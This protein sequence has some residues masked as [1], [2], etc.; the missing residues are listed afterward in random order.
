M[1]TGSINRSNTIEVSKA[2]QSELENAWLPLIES[3]V[4]TP[5]TD[6]RKSLLAR[7]AHVQ[8]TEV[9]EALNETASFGTLGYATGT[10]TIGLGN[11]SFGTTIGSGQAGF[12][13]GS[14]GSG[15]KWMSPFAIAMQVAAKTVGFDIVP[16]IPISAPTGQITYVDYEYSD[17]T[18]SGQGGDNPILI[19]ITTPS[20][21]TGVKQG[22]YLATSAYT[23]PTASGN[24][25]QLTYVG[26]TRIL[27]QSI[28]K[29]GLSGTVSGNVLT[30]T[31]T[32]ALSDVF[33][34]TANIFATVT[35]TSTANISTAVAITTTPDLV[36]AF[37]DQVT[38]FAGGKGGMNSAVFNDNYVDGLDY[39]EGMLRGES[40]GSQFRTMGLKTYN[41]YIETKEFKAAIS[42]TQ[43]QLQDMKRVHG[44]DIIAKAENAL[45]NEVSQNINKAILATAFAMGWTNHK[46]LVA[47]EGDNLN[48]NLVPGG[49]LVSNGAT[50]IDNTKTQVSLDIP[51]YQNYSS[52]T[53]GFDNQTTLIAR[54]VTK[55]NYA[56]DIILQRGRRGAA[57]FIVTNIKIASAIRSIGGYTF[58]P[59]KNNL[60]HNDLY[61]VGT[62]EGMTLYVDPNMKASDT[63]VLVGYKGAD[64]EPGLKFCSYILSESV[65]TIAEQTLAPKIGI[66][67]RYALVEYGQNPETQYLTFFVKIPDN[68][69]V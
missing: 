68:G 42:V 35:N 28:F 46:N 11:P 63:R 66:I 53:A 29:V 13:T 52:A 69:L 12:H 47:S 19:R 14:V 9:P 26:K 49:S 40:E 32:V 41:K 6:E 18:L 59:F 39:Y 22:T 37:E 7:M 5:M 55:I 30:S 38:G 25:V 24:G 27:G 58:Q 36:N 60:K 45:V 21:F 2:Y 57:N 17:G 50:Y 56:S 33:T 64:D 34:G 23:S 3:V 43:Q 67:S 54:L 51:A 8:Y 10:N 4:G 61:P 62:I 1:F 65:S 31:E 48:L 44:F 16:T 15:D 20:G